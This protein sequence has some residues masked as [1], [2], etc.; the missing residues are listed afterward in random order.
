MTR[1]WKACSN[2][3]KMLVQ[4][5]L[6]I[7]KQSQVVRLHL[8]L[9]TLSARLYSLPLPKISICLRQ[10][11]TLRL[12]KCEPN[13]DLLKKMKEPKFALS[14]LLVSMLQAISDHFDSLV[15]SIVIDLFPSAGNR[16]LGVLDFKIIWG[17]MS[18]E[19]LRFLLL[20]PPPSPQYS[21]VSNGLDQVVSL[22]K[23]YFTFACH[24]TDSGLVM[25]GDVGQC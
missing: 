12:E 16:F 20:P 19:P 7:P 15:S 4:H 11:K 25:I 10:S 18:P 6:Y 8:E 17:C 23:L 22:S 5:Y 14:S 21:F 3:S 1:Q 24:W 13:S 9:I 2:Q